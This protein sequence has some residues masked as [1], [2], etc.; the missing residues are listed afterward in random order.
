MGTLSYLIVQLGLVTLGSD[1]QANAATLSG[2]QRVVFTLSVVAFLVAFSDRFAD[3]LLRTLVGRFGG[4]KEGELIS[5][6]HDASLAA[7]GTLQAIIGQAVSNAMADAAP[8]VATL[9]DRVSAETTSHQVTTVV[10]ET[11]HATAAA[12]RAD[13][14]GAPTGEFDVSSSTPTRR[15]TRKSARAALTQAQ[16]SE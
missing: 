6:H 12:V 5:E 2:N 16:T 15:K 9:S 7:P 8:T 11:A 4:E 13:T 10:T 1:S 14:V 3:G